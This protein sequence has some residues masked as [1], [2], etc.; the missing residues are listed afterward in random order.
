M[1]AVGLVVASAVGAQKEPAAPAPS[2]PAVSVQSEG[3][4]P[5]ARPRTYALVAAVGEEIG[6]VSEGARTGT[7]MS[8]FR[9][10]SADVPDNLLNRFVLNMMDAAIVKLDSE[11]RRT[12]LTLAP[13]QLNGV[14]PMKREAATIEKI[15]AALR[16]MPQR[17]EWDRIVI[18]TPT[19]TSTDLEGLPGKLQGPGVF[20]Q[21][22]CQ[23]RMGKKSTDADSCSM[24]RRPPAGPE[25]T[26]PDDKII[27]V[28]YYVAP[29]FYMQLWVLNARTFEVID[30]QKV[31]DSKKIYDPKL[32][33]TAESQRRISR[34][35]VRRGDRGFR[36]A[37]GRRFGAPRSSRGRARARGAARGCS[38]ALIKLPSRPRAF[39]VFAATSNCE[40]PV[41][42]MWRP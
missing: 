4:A 40:R 2:E 38:T 1:L 36:P 29:F 5:S 7:H 33:P 12:Y 20:V 23:G 26:T 11:S 3:L 18:V 19:Y 14:E 16:P 42:L 10:T 13:G 28:N 25:A 6:V 35:P 22:A 27:R 31:F 39:R 17:A 8:Q 32:G 9:R 15:V 37:R 34:R 24:D 21:N 41:W 30:H